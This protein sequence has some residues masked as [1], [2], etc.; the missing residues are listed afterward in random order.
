MTPPRPFH[1]GRQALRRA[2]RARGFLCPLRAVWALLPAAG[3]GAAVFSVT[4]LGPLTDLPGRHE[5]QPKALNNQGLLAGANAVSNAYRALRY[6]GAAWRN[7]GTLGGPESAASGIND[8]GAV[9][10]YA[11]TAASVKRAFLWTA[12]GTNG[13]PANPQMQDLGTLGGLQSEASAINAAGHICGFADNAATTRAFL[14]TGTNLTDI[15]TW[16]QARLGLPTSFAY[17]LNATGAVVGAAYSSNLKTM[18]AFRLAGTNAVDLGDLGGGA[19]EALAV[20]DAGWA[21]GDSATAAG[22]D[23][24][25]LHDGARLRDLGTLGGRYS[26]ALGINRHGWV[27]GGSYVD[28]ADSVYRAFLYA[29]GAL[30]DLNTRLDASGSGWVLEEARAVNDAGQIAGT[31]RLDGRR[32][33]FLLTPV[34]PVFTALTAPG[35]NVVV[36]FSTTAASRYKLQAAD[37]PRGP[38]WTDVRTN[39]LGDG[40][41]LSVTNAGDGGRSA[42]FY[43]LRMAAP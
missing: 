24:A 29:D 14:R 33:A 43:R 36:R 11:L 35:S 37:D 4:N 2:P 21:V 31:G 38:L 22:T 7:L 39:L 13:S 41:P 28:S 23:H 27:V 12:G 5:A 6:D 10:G 42:R 26:Y 9:V 25:F 30:L 19:A 17:A 40:S 16:I 3:A 1:A 18:R 15:G 20:N 32:C 34:A 8:A